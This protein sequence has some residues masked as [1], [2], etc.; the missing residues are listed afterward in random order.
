LYVVGLS[1]P[2]LRRLR[3]LTYSAVSFRTAF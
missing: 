1:D 3:R 2:E